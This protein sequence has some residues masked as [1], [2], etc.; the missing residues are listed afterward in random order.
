MCSGR[1]DRPTFAALVVK[2]EPE[3]GGHHHLVVERFQRFSHDLLVGER[4]VDL[5]RV[6]KRHAAF[7]GRP[8]EGN[9]VVA[10]GQR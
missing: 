2:G 4:T 3:L 8:D 9:G 6:K 5:G 7:D 1:L 10:V